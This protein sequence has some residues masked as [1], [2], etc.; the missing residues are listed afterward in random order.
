MFDLNAPQ[1][2][3]L[4]VCVP[5]RQWQLENFLHSAL[6]GKAA[7]PP[8]KHGRKVGENEEEKGD[9]GAAGATPEAEQALEL[10]SYCS[11]SPPA[12]RGPSGT[13]QAEAVERAEPSSSSE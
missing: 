10:L 6:H 12:A 5:R 3:Y 1:G 8:P 2:Y 13:R 9:A 7:G 11:K 4:R